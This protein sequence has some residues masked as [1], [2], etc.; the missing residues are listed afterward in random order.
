MKKTIISLLALFLTM[1]VYAKK[2]H[3]E[4]EYQN[5][6]CSVQKGITEYELP[7]LTRV[8]CLTPKYA[9]EFDFGNKWAESIGQSLYYGLMTDRTPAVVLIMENPEREQKYLDRLNA[10]AEK[11]GIKVFTMKSLTDT[12]IEKE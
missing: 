2:L 1:P 10:V 6:W 4:S 12:N 11:H 7:D 5:A 9:V 8:D 3:Y